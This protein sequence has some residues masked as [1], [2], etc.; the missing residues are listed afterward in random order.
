MI[1]HL[2]T[3][4][5]GQIGSALVAALQ[6]RHGAAAVLATDLHDE[7]AGNGVVSAEACG[8]EARLG[9]EIRKNSKRAIARGSSQYEKLDVT[10][11]SG[12]ERIVDR[13]DIQVIYHLAS[14]LSVT[15]ERHPDRAWEVNVSGLKNILDLARRDGFQV[16]WPSSIAVFGP[17]TPRKQAPQRSLLDPRTMYGVTK[18]SGELLCQYYYQRF[19]VDVRSIRYPG[20]ISYEAPPGGGATDYAVEIFYAAVEG[21]TYSCFV[22]EDTQLPMMYMPDA[23]RASLELMDADVSSITVRT[24]YNIA[25]ANFTAGELAAAIREHVSDFEVVFEPD[26]RQHITDSW[27]DSVDDSVARYDWG[28]APRYDTAALCE[29]ML[30]KLSERAAESARGLLVDRQ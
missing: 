27:P 15:G 11:R 10:D 19:G 4:A 18:V 7:P 5:N 8:N 2:V 28:W 22:R 20:L 17:E 26:A 1:K 23:I 3:G 29:D 21:R 9:E 14:L 6:R 12:L 30:V 25:A 13:H 24:S 16:F